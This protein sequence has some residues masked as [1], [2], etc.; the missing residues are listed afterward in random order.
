MV[1]PLALTRAPDGKGGRGGAA[2]AGAVN[3]AGGAAGGGAAAAGGAGAAAGGAPGPI[4]WRFTRLP[5][6]AAGTLAT[7]TTGGAAASARSTDAARG[8]CAIA[9]RRRLHAGSD[10]SCALFEAAFIFSGVSPSMII[11][12]LKLLLTC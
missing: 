5:F 2:A 8:V 6:V 1:S 3:G 9:A 4:V 10:P 12:E 11:G 7:T